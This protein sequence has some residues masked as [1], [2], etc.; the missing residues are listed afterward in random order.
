MSFRDII[1]RI[2]KFE[3]RPNDHDMERLNQRYENR[4]VRLTLVN[5]AVNEILSEIQDKHLI[6][7]YSHHVIIDKYKFPSKYLDIQDEIIYELIFWFQH[8]GLPK[9]HIIVKRGDLI[10]IPNF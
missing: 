3:I 6:Q 5:N 4:K 8:N 9:A 7:D 2:R 1:G 10:I